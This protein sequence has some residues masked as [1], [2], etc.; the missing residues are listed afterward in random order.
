MVLSDTWMIVGPGHKCNNGF[1]MGMRPKMPPDWGVVLGH[2]DMLEHPCVNTCKWQTAN[3]K[4]QHLQQTA[5]GHAL[6]EA[7]LKP[8][9]WGPGMAGDGSGRCSNDHHDLVTILRHTFG[10]QFM[11]IQSCICFR[12]VLNVVKRC[13]AGVAWGVV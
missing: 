2:T 5:V 4:R 6:Q 3:G 12:H 11:T 1:L 9:E 13:G 8:W 7:G 10:D